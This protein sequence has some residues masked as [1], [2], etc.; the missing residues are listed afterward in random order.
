MVPIVEVPVDHVAV[1]SLRGSVEFDFH[2]EQFDPLVVGVE[3]LV[4]SAL[5]GVNGRASSPPWP[6]SSARLVFEFIFAIFTV[7]LLIIRSSV[8]LNVLNAFCSDG[9]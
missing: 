8:S 6:L 7:N 1:P 9:S 5:L 3:G 4:A 2:P